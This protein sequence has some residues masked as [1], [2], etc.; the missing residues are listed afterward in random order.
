[1]RGLLLRFVP[2]SDLPGLS[3]KWLRLLEP[4]LSLVKPSQI[5]EAARYVGVILRKD[6]AQERKGLL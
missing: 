2:V 4:A 6:P 5:I 3:Q 1:M